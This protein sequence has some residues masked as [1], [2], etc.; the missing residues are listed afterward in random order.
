MRGRGEH[1]EELAVRRIGRGR[2]GHADRAAIKG[3]RREF[4]GQIGAAGPAHAR[5]GQISAL[6]A[7]GD[8]AGLGHEAIDDPVKDD[9]VIGAFRSKGRDLFDVVGGNIRQKIDHDRAGR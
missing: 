7:V 4:G 9:A 8:I 6:F 5:H 3:N 1:D 2:P